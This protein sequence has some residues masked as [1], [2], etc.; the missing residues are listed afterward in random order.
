VFTAQDSGKEATIGGR[1]GLEPGVTLPI[2]G[3]RLAQA[4]QLSD[5]FAYGLSVS[6]GVQVTSISLSAD[7]RIAPEVGHAFAHGHPPPRLVL[8]AVTACQDANLARII[9]RGFNAQ[10]VGRV[11]PFDGITFHGMFDPPAFGTAFEVGEDFAFER[12]NMDF[13]ELT[14]AIK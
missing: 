11:V 1:D 3:L 10:D 8:R 4:I 5:S 9:D 7:L 6:Q 2:F 14:L 13:W 12:L